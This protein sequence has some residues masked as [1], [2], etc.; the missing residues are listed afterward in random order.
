MGPQ[1]GNGYMGLL[2][3]ISPISLKTL[4]EL[5]SPLSSVSPDASPGDRSLWVF[6]RER[7]SWFCTLAPV[8]WCEEGEH[9]SLL[10]LI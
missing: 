1:N 5:G 3:S 10:M 9:Q 8:V 4:A 2:F 6:S 7:R